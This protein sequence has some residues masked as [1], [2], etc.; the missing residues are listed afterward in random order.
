MTEDD[1]DNTMAVAGCFIL[2]AEALIATAIG[3][4]FGY[5]YGLGLYGFALLI[6][7][8]NAMRKLKKEKR[9]CT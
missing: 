5:P 8:M 1:R 2:V 7:S 9:R 6:H 3:G 4:V